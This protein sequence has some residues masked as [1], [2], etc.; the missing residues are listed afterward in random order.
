M[1]LLPI[2]LHSTCIRYIIQTIF[3]ISHLTKA[4]YD[5][6]SARLITRLSRVRLPYLFIFKHDRD[7]PAGLEAAVR[8]RVDDQ[9]EFS[10]LQTLDDV[11]QSRVDLEVLAEVAGLELDPQVARQVVHEVQVAHALRWDALVSFL[12]MDETFIFMARNKLL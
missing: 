8:I 4:S 11:V 7:V 6:T 1:P 2:P 5:D 12:G 3:M 9:V 10:G